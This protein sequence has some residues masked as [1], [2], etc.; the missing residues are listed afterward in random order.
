DDV[1]TIHL[2]YG[3]QPMGRVWDTIPDPDTRLPQGGFNAYDV[4]FSDAPWS[5]VGAAISKTA[6]RFLFALTQA[7]FMMRDP[8]FGGPDRDLL[9]ESSL[10]ESLKDTEVRREEAEREKKELRERSLYPEFDYQDQ[11]NGYAWGMSIDLNSCVGCNACMIACQSE[12][13]I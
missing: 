10:E 5:A 12:N 3:R 11:G 4:R 9:R 6:E 2:G 1:I 8:A 7:H 13:N